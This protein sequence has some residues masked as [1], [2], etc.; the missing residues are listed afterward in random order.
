MP[1]TVSTQGGC[2]ASSVSLLVDGYTSTQ[3]CSTPA[4]S[5]TFNVPTSCWGSDPHTIEGSASCRFTESD[6]HCWPQ[7]GQSGPQSVSQNNQP[8]VSFN[9]SAPDAF[10]SVTITVNAQFM[11]LT[12]GYQHIRVFR[13]GN[14][15]D[16]LGS[17]APP[18]NVQNHTWTFTTNINCVAGPLVLEA[19]AM[20]CG[21]P[22]SGSGN[23]VPAD[24]SLIAYSG[25]K[26]IDTEQKPTATLAIGPPDP[27]SGV[28]TA[29]V[30]GTFKYLKPGHQYLRLFRNGN[31]RDVVHEERPADGATSHTFT[32]DLPNVCGTP[33]VYEAAAMTCGA[34]YLVI[35]GDAVPTN[36]AFIGLSGPQTPAKTYEPSVDLT[37][38]KS[39]LPAATGVPAVTATIAFDFK[40][41]TGNLYLY[42]KAW[43]DADGTTHPEVEVARWMG[44]NN[45]LSPIVTEV[46][47][48]SGS[49]QITLIVKAEACGT[50]TDEASI[51]CDGPGC[52]S[53]DPV[54]FTDGNVRVT[55]VDPLPPISNQRLVRTYNSDEQVIALF[56]RG[57]TTLFE[58]RLMAGIDNGET[59]V[60]VVSAEN[61]VVTFRG[62]G[63]TFRQ[64]W[65]SATD[66]R[67]TLRY[68]AGSAT[69]S[70]RAAGSTEVAVFRA[71]DGRLTAL[72]DV[73][74]GREAQIAYA[75]SS[76][77]PGP[78]SSRRVAIQRQIR[79]VA[80]R[81]PKA[82]PPSPCCRRGRP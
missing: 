64:T 55:D 40:R 4:C 49:Q 63:S 13:E 23:P 24:P 16:V 44:I 35:G 52:C 43:V 8:S 42:R 54:Y 6:G 79:C 7:T 36:S 57:F 11:T 14:L 41:P 69:Y 77:V 25:P 61:E 74:T 26:T 46:P 72:R 58:R 48:P 71:S 38:Q 47:R 62:G 50:A 28:A 65:P 18:P 75:G 56:G 78:R 66:A 68:D 12:N 21:A 27:A 30:S 10:G 67:G 60:S 39:M 76:C 81:P 73:A 31:I 45:T 1:V 59:V 3:S 22:S 19:A 2:G 82:F 33:T 29:T 51:G 70:H 34:S 53:L 37:V 80:A 5:A 9:A 17:T 20:T 15:Y 32:V